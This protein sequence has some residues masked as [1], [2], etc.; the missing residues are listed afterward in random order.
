MWGQSRESITASYG[1]EDAD[2]ASQWTISSAITKTSGQGNTGTYAG[3]ISTNTTTVQYNDKVNVTSFSYA[4]K[5]TSNNSNYSVNIQTSTD[6]ETWN[7]VDNQTMGSFNNG[8]YKTVTKTFDGNTAYYVRFICNNT[9]AVRYVDDV[10]IVYNTTAS[11][12]FTV[13]YDCNGGETDCPENVSGIAPGTS[14]TLASAPSRPHYNFVGWTYGATTYDPGDSYTVNSNVTFV[15]QWESDGTYGEGTICFSNQSSCTAINSQSVTGE[16]DLGNT[17][18]ITTVGTNSFTSNSGYYQVGSGNSPATSIT[19]TTTLD[20]EVNVTDF[21]AMFGG[22]S[23]TRASVVLK[24]DD[25]Q[26]GSGTLNGAADVTVSSSSAQIGTTLTVIVTPTAGGVKCYNISYAYETIDNPAVATTTTINVPAN[27]NNDIYQGTTAGTLTATVSAEG[28]PI[29]GATVTWSSSNTG[30]ATIDA[31][32]EVTLV[33]VG[34]TTITANYAGVEDE[35]RPS[36]GTYELTVT[37]SNAPGTQ[38]NPYTVAQAIYAIDNNGNMTGV[39]ATGIVSNV[40]YYSENNHYITYYISADGSTTGDQLEAFHGK[41]INGADFSSIDDI[42]VGDVVVIYGNLTKYNSTY[43][44]AA[45]N[46]LVSLVRPQ[47]TDPSVTVTPNTINAPFAGA[48]GTLALT[49]ENIEEFI[50]FDYYFCDANGNELEDT[51]PDY[52]G[53]WIDAE[54]NEENEAYTL[55]YII[56]ANDGAARTAYVKVYTYDDELEEVSAIVTV[57]QAQYVV[58][59]AT[60]PFEWE[61]GASADFLALNGVTAHGL[62]SDYGSNNAPYLIKFD[63]TG[64]YIQVKTNEQPGKVTIGVKMIGGA[65]TSTIT[66]QGSADGETFTDVEELTIS[67]AQNDVLTLET[68]NAFAANVRY[69]RMLFTKGSNV[70]VGPISIAVVSNEASIA[71][72]PDEVNVDAEEHDGTLDLTYENLTITDMTDFD[73][74]FC[75]ANG[76]ELSEEPDWIEVLVAEQ[77]PEI[78]EGYVVSYYMVENEGPDARTAYFKV[79][80]MDDETNLVYSNLVTISQAAPVAPVTGDKYVKVT[81]TADLT[82]GQYLIVYEEGSVAFDGSLETL[83]AASNT[84][85]VTINDSEIDVDNITTAAEFTIDMTVGTIKS[86]SGYYIGRTGD[87][88]GMNT[89]ATEAYTNTISIDD[90]GNAVVVASGGAYLRYNA[91]SG[92][93]RFRYFKS[94]S[95][96]GQKAIQLY[97]KVGEEPATE[98]HTLTVD[99]YTNDNTKDGYNLIASPVN[100]DPATVAGMTTGDFDLYSFDESQADEWRNYEAAAFN[101]VPGKGYLYAKKATTENQTYTFQLTGIPYNNEPITLSKSESGDFPGWNLV[102]NPFGETAVLSDN[103]DFYVMNSDG[104]DFIQGSGAIAPMQGIFVIAEHDREELQ[105]TVAGGTAIGPTEDS[106]L[107]LNLTKGRGI[108]DRAVVRFGEG[109]TLPKFMLN[110]DNTKLYIT[111]GNQDYAVVR[112]NNAG[113]MPV[114]FKAAENGNYTLSIEAENVEASYLHLIDN[115]TGADV[116]L[117]ATP[118]YSFEARTTDYANRFRLVFNTNGVEENTMS[119]FAYFNGSSWTIDNM[120]EATLQVVDVMGR[121][122]S[123]ETISGNTEVNLNQAAGVYMLRLVT[124]NDVKVQK[125]VVR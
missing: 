11:T 27:F 84:I 58:D 64:D 107:V 91:T 31:N 37:D 106:K 57:N 32:G 30:V 40:D 82:S 71:V 119:N 86:A 29:S 10:T 38:N 5:R 45:D 60:L 97:K 125:V 92:Q 24:V 34:T 78:G 25:T 47:D 109:R 117:L 28:A 75:D 20:E 33:A 103:R 15:A 98:T 61:G 80:A 79:Y 114:S 62:G 111:E 73:I 49:Y 94:S 63:G 72:N 50:S 48:E 4:F 99:G 88:N 44:F 87:S 100:V 22:F 56:E 115:M 69:V 93:D 35:Y 26:V 110:A 2:D 36:T 96:T 39:Y 122:L 70:G 54:I 14:I 53:D 52:P 124:G 102:G 3:K 118:S 46:E 17:W 18:T 23:A 7:T 113:E 77:D 85:E 104:S 83:D 89:S 12:T 68:T 74:Q 121:V 65:S 90:N 67:G 42:Q 95:Y 120:G 6:G 108:I 81:S 105:I 9:T 51:D 8:T 43:E 66:I 123:T 112:S 59:Y 19:F 116:N 41:G 55:S 16:D 13:N 76:E 101:L 1:W 21:S